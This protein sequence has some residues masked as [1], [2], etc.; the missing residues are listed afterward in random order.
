MN[1]RPMSVL[2]W[3]LAA[4]LMCVAMSPKPQSELV[5]QSPNGQNMITLSASDDGAVFRLSGGDGQFATVSVNSSGFAGMWIGR[6]SSEPMAAIY[7][8]PGRHHAVV[9]VYQDHGSAMTKHLIAQRK[10]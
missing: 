2:P 3:C 1:F 10:Q 6:K 4:V 7:S 8:D 9:G 5:L